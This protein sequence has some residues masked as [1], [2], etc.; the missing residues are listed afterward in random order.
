MI[1][2][3]DL[4]PKK[5]KREVA[6]ARVIGAFEGWVSLSV[7]TGMTIKILG[8]GYTVGQRVVLAMPDGNLANAQIIGLATGQEG[9]VEHITLL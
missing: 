3:R 2:P 6:T 7:H 8:E 1:E 9:I 4:L 5:S